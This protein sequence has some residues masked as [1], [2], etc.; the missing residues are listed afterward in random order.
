MTDQLKV[1]ILGTGGSMGVP[2]IGNRWGQCDPTNPKNRRRRPSALIEQGGT[3][4]LVDTSTDL[5]DQ[6]LD[7]DVK[8]VDGVLYTH[9]HADHVHGIDDLRSVWIQ[10]RSPIKMMATQ[11]TMRDITRRFSYLFEDQ[12]NGLYP[13]F[14]NPETFDIGDTLKFRSL[15]PIK[16][17]A[18]DHGT[19]IS[20]GLRIGSLAYST[21]VANLD[22][23]AFEVLEGV[24][25][26][27]VDSCRRE[28]HPAHAHL[29][30]TLEWI[31]RLKPKRAWL[32]HM[33]Q[34]MDYEDVMAETPDNVEPA[35]DGLV[36]TV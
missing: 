36:I 6:L 10:M 15:P 24:E 16:T 4:L 28:P 12:T 3:T 9:S 5:R 34:T 11:E 2:L 19:C 13:V 1:T 31:D 21:D 33:N 20:V 27:I 26:W 25:Y 32:T 22:E 35:Y 23:A 8:R 17:F 7:A 14:L 29:E 18:Q 30:R